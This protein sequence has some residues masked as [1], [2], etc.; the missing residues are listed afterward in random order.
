MEDSL[1]A[2]TWFENILWQWKMHICHFPLGFKWLGSVKVTFISW[3][4]GGSATPA[5]ALIFHFSA[6]VWG[7]TR[8][9]TR[10]E[11]SYIVLLSPHPKK[12]ICHWRKQSYTRHHCMH[13]HPHLFH[14]N[15]PFIKI[16]KSKLKYEAII[17]RG[18]HPASCLPSTEGLRHGPPLNAATGVHCGTR[19]SHC[20]HHLQSA[21]SGW[22]Q[23]CSTVP[24]SHHCLIFPN[25]T[26]PPSFC[27]NLPRPQSFIINIWLPFWQRC[28]YCSWS[29]FFGAV[30]VVRLTL[31]ILIRSSD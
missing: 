26:T 10:T 6:L 28:F 11:E 1:H 25:P 15:S 16:P 27:C 5:S 21:S 22:H 13:K 29:F 18:S 31:C 14:P 30:L 4:P 17:P 23:R 2:Y 24:L 9:P 19:M 7:E 20:P 8:K 3:P 12:T